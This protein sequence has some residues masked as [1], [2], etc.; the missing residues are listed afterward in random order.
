M[1]LLAA[2]G[3]TPYTDN[4]READ[5]NNPKGYFETVKAKNLPNTNTWLEECCG[6]AVKV[7]APLI[8]FL[9]QRFKYRMIVMNRNIEEILQ[10]QTQMLERL[11]RTGG[12]I[13]N[14]RLGNLLLKQ[15]H[16]IKTIM[17]LHSIPHIEIDFSWAVSNP[18]AIVEQLVGFIPECSNR[19]AMAEVI[20][21]QL[22]REKPV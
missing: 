3:L 4:V 21:P 10:S 11:N 20:D 5:E 6:K 16:D 7:I 19:K 9:P 17:A 8:Q 18:S 12:A 15:F 13:E 2:G 22:Y 14:E 1:Q